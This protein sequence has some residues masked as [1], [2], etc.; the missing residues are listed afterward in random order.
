M[1]DHQVHSEHGGHSHKADCG[2]TAVRHAGHVDYVHEG[3]L[4][5][6]HEGHWDECALAITAENPNACTASHVCGGHATGHTHGATCGH[7]AVPHAGHIDYWV[8]G[9]LHHP[10]GGHCDMH[11]A[12]SAS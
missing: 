10:H 11:G 12:L 9:H 7:E 6:G 8:S 3:H 4:H 1:A 2:H 5:H